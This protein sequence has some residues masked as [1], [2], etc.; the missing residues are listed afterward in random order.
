MSLTLA[1]RIKGAH[2]ESFL[3]ISLSTHFLSPAESPGAGFDVAAV[4]TGLRCS[5]HVWVLQTTI[6][7]LPPLRAAV[8][9][10]QQ[11][12]GGPAH[13]GRRRR[14]PHSGQAQRER[15]PPAEPPQ[16]A[17]PR[18]QEPGGGD[19]DHGEEDG[20]ERQRAVRGLDGSARSC[21]HNAPGCFKLN[22]SRCISK[23]GLSGNLRQCYRRKNGEFSSCKIDEFD[24]LFE[25]DT[26]C[27]DVK[28]CT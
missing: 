17:P 6:S 23:L 11:G 13:R 12:P 22:T 3:L 8:P 19:P 2:I 5:Q 10:R 24:C 25:G 14:D 20:G 1:Y 4:S 16:P 27:T 21:H 7:L 18:L 9:L 28:Y 15:G 26:V